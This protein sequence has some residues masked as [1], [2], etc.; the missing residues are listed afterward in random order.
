MALT[1]SR[2]TAIALLTSALLPWPVTARPCRADSV[3]PRPA[4]AAPA[5]RYFETHDRSRLVPLLQEVLRFKT[6]AGETEAHAAQ[7]KWLERTATA[8]GFVVRDAGPVTEI[9]LPG[10][11][12]A[13]VLGLIIHGDVQPVEE[14]AWRDPPFAGIVRDGSVWGRGAADDKG[15]LV[16]T[17]LALKAMRE[18]K[19]RRTHTVRLLVGSDEESGSTDLPTYL[20]DHKAPDYSLV[21]DAIF[22]VVVGEKGWNALRVSVDPKATTPTGSWE[23]VDLD[24]GLA[25][26]I[27]PDTARATLRPR[28]DGDKAAL[29]ARVRARAPLPD[30]RLDVTEKDGDVVLEMHGRA[31]HAGVN[32]EGGR[33]ALVSL[34]H[35]LGEDTPAGPLGDLLRFAGRAGRDVR[36]AGLELPT[37]DALWHGYDVN[38]ATVKPLE[39]RPTLTINIRRPP[40]WTG[41]ALRRHLEAQVARWNTENGAQLKMDPEF[42]FADEPLVIDPGSPLVVRTLEAYRRATGDADAPPA[43][44][45]GGTYAKRV[46]RAVAFGAWFSGKPYPGHDVDE[47]V[48]IDDL[49]RGTHVLIETFVDIAC[50][51]PIENAIVGGFQPEAK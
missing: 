1:M 42:F 35:V 6:V 26:S 3:K 7:K 45:G 50:G 16:Q 4:D 27:V 29:L 5:R 10:P 24:A 13:P 51:P 15:P 37:P 44:M 32:L 9:E 17:L 41:D 30:T 22:P 49:V 21:I 47:H 19:T 33:N 43:V 2:A 46:P 38:V 48:P 12:G 39:G 11:A 23:I 8:M 36:G 25:A 18:T 20:K 14:K 34:A 28:G 31:A 40:P